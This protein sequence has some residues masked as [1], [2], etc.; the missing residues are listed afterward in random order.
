[1]RTLLAIDQSTSTTKALLLDA[2]GRLLKRAARE[3]QQ[4][5]PAPGYV[6]HNAEEIWRNVVAVAAQVVERSREQ[7]SELA[8][9][10]IANQRETVVIFECGS[11]SPLIPAITWQ[12]RRG[13]ALCI[14]Q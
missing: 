11:G 6:E 10:S 13:A 2:N 4:I 5:Y 9:V 8:C 1:M 3:H 7:S 14:V 12:C